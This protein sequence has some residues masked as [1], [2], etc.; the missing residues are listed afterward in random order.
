MARPRVY[1]DG[2]Q[3]PR[4][5]SNWLPKYGR[6]RGKQTYRCQQCLYHFIPETKHPH[7]PER[8]KDMA[9]AMYAEGNSI[10]AIS[11]I[12]EIK[13]GTVYS[14]VKKSLPSPESATGRGR[15]APEP[16]PRTG[17]AQGHILR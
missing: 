3:C 10:E 16:Q 17:V 5:G 15:A 14:W 12:L 4:C 13:A 11:R 8:V 1:R 9:V 6:P 7:Q 2:M